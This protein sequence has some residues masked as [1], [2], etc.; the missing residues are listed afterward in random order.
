M[1]TAGH[2]YELA[3]LLLVGVLLWFLHSVPEYD[4]IHTV[5]NDRYVYEI[6]DLASESDAVYALTASLCALIRPGNG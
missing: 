6:V 2:S 1:L 4:L 5:N 3:T